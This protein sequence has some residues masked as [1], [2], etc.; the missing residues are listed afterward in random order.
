[1]SEPRHRKLTA[2]GIASFL[3]TG[4]TEILARLPG[5]IFNLWLDVFGEIKEA[6]NLSGS[7]ADSDRYVDRRFSLHC[8]PVSSSPPP[9][10]RY[11]DVDEAPSW[12]YQNTEGT[13][14]YERRKAV[15]ITQLEINGS[16]C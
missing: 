12:F 15:C 11:W 7:Y 4:K 5:E 3:S 13:P 16:A 14:E 1:M 6:Q 9:L 8:L 10:K 2:M